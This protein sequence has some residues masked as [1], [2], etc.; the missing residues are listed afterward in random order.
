MAQFLMACVFGC[1]AFLVIQAEEGP[2]S[3]AP[4]VGALI[5]GFGGSWAVTFL[6]AWARFGWKAARGMRMG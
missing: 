3:K 1:A 5:A 2:N 4:L 6:I